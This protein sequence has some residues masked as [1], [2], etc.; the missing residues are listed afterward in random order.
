M[1]GQVR[2]R[3]TGSFA[4]T[5]CLLLLARV[6]GVAQS[7]GPAVPGTYSASVWLTPKGFLERLK[8]VAVTLEIQPS[9]QQYVPAATVRS[10][11]LRRLTER[12]ISAQPM[13]PVRLRAQILHHRAVFTSQRVSSASGAVRSSVEEPAQQLVVWLRFEVATAVLRQDT[14]HVLDVVPADGYSMR[15]WTQ[16]REPLPERLAKELEQGLSD[17]LSS[18]ATNDEPAEPSHWRAS[19]WTPAVSS[20]IHT[21]FVDALKSSRREPR[22]FRGVNTEPEISVVI[23]ESGGRF[24]SRR[25]LEALWQAQFKRLG[26]QRSPVTGVYLDHRIFAVYDDA[27]TA[28]RAWGVKG[29]PFHHL[30]DVLT[31][32]E[33]DVVYALDGVYYRSDVQ[34]R[35]WTRNGFSLL[36]ETKQ[37]LEQQV[38]AAIEEFGREFLALR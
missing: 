6:D 10:M 11:L 31:L 24:I 21:R 2:S 28:S 37:A 14:F 38:T 32:N 13:A 16:E 27:S 34:L 8:T 30:S 12:G 23:G 9:V 29:M 3:L 5:C 33:K 22:T 25:D 35:A 7:P 18:V 26:L 20:A 36:A 4:L 19:E 17:A 15:A 1:G